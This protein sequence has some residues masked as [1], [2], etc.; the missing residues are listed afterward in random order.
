VRRLCRNFVE[1]YV[2]TPL[3]ECERRDPK[4]LYARA[5]RGEI[6]NFTGISDPYEPP[7]KAEVVIDTTSTTVEQLRDRVMSAI[8]DA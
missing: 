8:P 4:G 6:E 3:A 2:A 5:R 7:P 1:V